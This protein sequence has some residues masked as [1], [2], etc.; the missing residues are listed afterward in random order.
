LGFDI[1]A[2]PYP[3]H[4]PFRLK[5]LLAYENHPI[6]V[7]AKDAI[8]I[9]PLLLTALDNASTDSRVHDLVQRLWVLPVNAVLSKQSYD[10]L[11]QQL[12]A[13]N[14]LPTE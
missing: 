5:E 8:K 1:V 13:L 2:H 6:V 4:H 10:T 9:R 12:A 3:D 14:V 11:Q 7:T